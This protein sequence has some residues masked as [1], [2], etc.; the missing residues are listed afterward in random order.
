MSSYGGT[1]CGVGAEGFASF[2]CQTDRGLEEQLQGGPYT[3]R[4]RNLAR[5]GSDLSGKN[6]PRQLESG[7]GDGEGFVIG[8]DDGTVVSDQGR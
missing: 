7:V 6:L 1:V 8:R 4:K 2:P 3:F 5:E